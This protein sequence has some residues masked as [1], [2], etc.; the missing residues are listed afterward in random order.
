MAR[1]YWSSHEG[2]SEGFEVPHHGDRGEVDPSSLVPGCPGG[3]ILTI[4][5]EAGSRGR[6]IGQ[7]LG[8]RLSWQVYDRE[9][10]EYLASDS[11]ASSELFGE[12]DEAQKLW[13]NDQWAKLKLRLGADL[14]E[15]TLSLLR[16]ILALGVKGRVILVGRGAHWILPESHTLRVRVV[17]T[18]E[19]RYAYLAQTLR[20][21]PT[22]AQHRCRLRDQ[23]RQDFARQAFGFQIADPVHYDMVL[24][25]SRLGEEVCV[26]LM[27]ETVQVKERLGLMILRP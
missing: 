12:L 25:S 16:V 6:A 5:R 22:E 10:M 19:D 27:H 20:L 7:R 23:K 8:Q 11:V 14:G 18:R 26:Q 4:S 15:G 9:L 2:F 3:P 17:G 21:S 13:V 1:E 24:N